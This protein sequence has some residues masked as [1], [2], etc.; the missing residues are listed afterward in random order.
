MKHPRFEEFKNATK[1]DSIFLNNLRK[2]SI[3]YHKNINQDKALFLFE[4]VV[5]LEM[6]NS[7]VTPDGTRWLF[8]NSKVE[9][10]NIIS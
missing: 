6:A 4:N 10:K 7:I 9:K 5:N 8:L 2:R 3:F 1:F